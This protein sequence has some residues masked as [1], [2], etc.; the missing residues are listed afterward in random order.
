MLTVPLITDRT[1]DD[2]LYFEDMRREIIERILPPEHPEWHEEMRGRY[3]PYHT[4]NRIGQAKIEIAAFIALFYANA[5]VLPKIDWP[6]PTSGSEEDMPTEEQLQRYLEDVRRIHRLISRFRSVPDVPS[7]MLHLTFEEANDI[8]QILQ[9]AWVWALEHSKLVDAIHL[10]ANSLFF[11]SGSTL[12]INETAQKPHPLPPRILTTDLPVGRIGI[13]YSAKIL[14]ENQ[15]ALPL[16]WEIINGALPD[17][18]VIVQKRHSHIILEGIPTLSA[19]GTTFFT[20]EIRNAVGATYRRRLSIT[21][22]MFEA[23]VRAGQIF[24][25]AGSMINTLEATD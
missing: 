18:V 10:L 20:I 16:T 17:G 13:T 1:H 9:I 19:M 14:A 23:F 24:A 6:K 25:H 11:R 5:G 4:M 15:S 12:H 2:Y 7:S 22:V 3:T 8:E 21:V